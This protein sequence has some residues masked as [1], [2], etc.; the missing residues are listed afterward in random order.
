MGSARSSPVA[1][2]PSSARA[3]ITSWN[4]VA[5]EQRA[6]APSAP[7]GERLRAQRQRRRRLD[8]VA[9][10]RPPP[11]QRASTVAGRHVARGTRPAPRPPPGAPSGCSS[12]RAGDQRRPRVRAR[13][14]AP[15]PGPPPPAP[16]RRDPRPAPR[17]RARCVSG[18]GCSARAR[19]A[20][21]PIDAQLGRRQL[22][23]PQRARLVQLHRLQD[24]VAGIEDD[25]R[26][27]ARAAGSRR[28][29]CARA[30][31]GSASASPPPPPAPPSTSKPVDLVAL[32]L[33]L[34]L[35]PPDAAVG[36]PL[37]GCLPA[38]GGRGCRS[39]GRR[40]SPGCGP[41]ASSMARRQVA[42]LHRAGGRVFRRRCAA[43]ARTARRPARAAACA[44]PGRPFRR[45]GCRTA[46]SAPRTAGRPPARWY[47]P[48][49]PR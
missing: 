43:P 18:P 28:C 49:S 1:P 48:A 23:D 40:S 42:R 7:A 32:L 3:R 46:R 35:Q 12:A 6:A 9:G 24:D 36:V 21:K 16:P 38:R 37:P 44:A 13:G 29:G 33:L 2:S 10:D 19:A 20:S 17:A 47:L 39:T 31:P 5:V 45:G 30:P 4:D 8:E 25:L 15:A 22:A 14:S 11:A 26:R 34:Q 41:V 27:A